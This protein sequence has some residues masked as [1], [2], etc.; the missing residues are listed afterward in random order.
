MVDDLIYMVN[1]AGI[2]SCVEAK[3]GKSVWTER[4]G[5]NYTS[6]PVYADGKLYFFSQDGDC[7]VLA[8]GRKFSLLAKNELIGG[9]MASP[10]V[11]DNALLVRTRTHLYR[12][13]GK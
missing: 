12:I 10:A 9:C 11:A 5:G 4:V 3:T 8:P 13:E 7:P 6:S 1:D 2:F